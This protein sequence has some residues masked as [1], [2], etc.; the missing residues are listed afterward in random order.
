MAIYRAETKHVTRSK[1]HNVVAA[2][3]YR[4]GEKLTDKNKFNPEAKT[5]DYSKKKG[6]V[7]NGI[8][9]PKNLI[10][11][12]FEI[13]RQTLW[14][15][16]E[17]SEIT[18]R[19]VKGSRLKSARLA[20]EW[21]LALPHELTD[22]DN[23]QLTREFT[24]YM[25]NELGVIADFAI[26]K[27]TPRKA[28]KDY[29]EVYNSD[30]WKFEKQPVYDIEPSQP[31]SRNVHAHIL[32]TT[33]KADLTADGSLKFGN[34]ADSERSEK[35]RK[36]QGLC[37]GGDYIKEVREV[38]ANMVNKRLE[39]RNIETVSH[40]S[41]KDRGLDKKPQFKKGKNAHALSLY[42]TKTRIDEHNEQIKKYNDLL[43]DISPIPLPTPSFSNSFS[44]S[45]GFSEDN[46]FFDFEELLVPHQRLPFEDDAELKPLP[47]NTQTQQTE[48]NVKKESNNVKKES[49]LL[50]SHE[51]KLE[52][53]RQKLNVAGYEV[54][55]IDTSN[56]NNK[57]ESK[58]NENTYRPRPRF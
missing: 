57:E 48:N 36:E 5:H 12:G 23:E 47:V 35:W 18:T 3:A 29:I 2:A 53:L 45:N 32:F 30:T 7:S 39:S 41:Y 21:L 26:H 42:G 38:W 11:K 44:S 6:V 4:A 40:K 10:E 54:I 52:E 9:L 55:N 37:N 20:R 8:I 13:D 25:V 46:D 43:A 56:E 17:E 15:S 14:S 50:D 22:E 28:K 51:K 49:S 34:K 33:R 1:N 24:E 27:P 31:D 58:N 19:S 16:V